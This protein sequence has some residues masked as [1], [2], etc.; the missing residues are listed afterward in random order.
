MSPCTARRASTASPSYRSCRFD[1]VRTRPARQRRR[2]SVALY[3]G[4]D[5]A[6]RAAC[7]TVASIYAPN[8]NPI[9]HGEVPLQARLAGAPAERARAAARRRDAARAGRRLQRH[10][11]ARSTPSVRT[12]GPTTR[13]SSRETRAAYRTLAQ[14]RPD[15]CAAA[16]PSRARHL[17]VLGLSG[18]RLPEGRRHPHRPSA[19][20]AAGDRPA[21]SP[22]ASTASRA[23]GRSRRTTCRSGSSSTSSP[24]SVAR[25]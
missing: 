14:P 10:S 17:H 20:V 9:G 8:G 22:P 24:R 7:V 2:R 11:R 15:R 6:R 3:R 4:H 23:P 25:D 18:R 19:P 5:L 1:E 12:R 13:S 21:W 16:L